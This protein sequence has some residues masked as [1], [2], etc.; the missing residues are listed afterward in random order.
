MD[1]DE[2][3]KMLLLISKD[4]KENEIEIA[5]KKFDVNGDKKVTFE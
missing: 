2:F 3:K 1:Y 5:F 4:L